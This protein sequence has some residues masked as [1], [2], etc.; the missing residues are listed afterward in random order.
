MLAHEPPVGAL[1][2]G[3]VRL[4]ADAQQ[5]V[6]LFQGGA[7]GFGL[8]PARPGASRPGP[9]LGIVPAHTRQVL[10]ATKDELRDA[11]L[12][13]DT[14]QDVLLGGGGQAVGVSGLDLDLDEHLQ[15]GGAA[16][17][18]PPE[19]LQHPI[20]VE[21]V[22]LTLVEQGDGG[23]AGLRGKLHAPD[24]RL[25]QGDLLGRHPAIGLGHVAE[26]G[27]GGGEK[28]GL[29]PLA[30]ARFGPGLLRLEG[31]HALVELMPDHASQEGTDG[32]SQH[33]AQG[34]ADDLAP[35]CHARFSAPAA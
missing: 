26:D 29:N 10:Q 33:E 3:L 20:Q 28:G 15:E 11:Q 9:A 5:F 16:M 2:L 12:V 35:P 17:T 22:R 4:G 13:A 30:V 7:L 8:T 24:H 23:G 21:V 32:P 31:G 14:P 1:D 34:P 27:E 19:L 25:G 18:L 6:G